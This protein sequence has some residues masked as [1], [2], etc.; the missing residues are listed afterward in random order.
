MAEGA[1]LLSLAWSGK[2][3]LRAKSVLA[4]YHFTAYDSRA[5]VAETKD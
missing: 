5:A 4:R 3:K 2:N 1:S